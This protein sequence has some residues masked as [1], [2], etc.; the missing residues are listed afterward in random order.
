MEDG[1]W[2]SLE[3][4]KGREKWEN[5]VSKSMSIFPYIYNF[6]KQSGNMALWVECLT[7]VQETLGSVP[8]TTKQSRLIS[9]EHIKLPD[10]EWGRFLAKAE[11]DRSIACA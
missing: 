10:L 7:T 3:V 8:S 9:K 6:K 4:G 11:R 1:T 5:D 2:Q